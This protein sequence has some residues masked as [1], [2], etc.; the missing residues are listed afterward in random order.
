[1]HTS[2]DQVRKDPHDP[3]KRAV[4]A[5]ML[6]GYAHNNNSSGIGRNA[7]AKGTQCVASDLLSTSLCRILVSE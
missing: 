7:V 6:Y 2:L 4:V 1:M 3:A 5:H